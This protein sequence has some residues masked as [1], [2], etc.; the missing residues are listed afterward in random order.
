MGFL[1]RLFG[2]EEQKPAPTESRSDYR[3]QV[4]K[5]AQTN[6]RDMG[7]PN[8]FN[9]STPARPA[10]GSQAQKYVPQNPAPLKD[11]HPKVAPWEGTITSPSTPTGPPEPYKP[12][13]PDDW[14]A[15]DVQGATHSYQRNAAELKRLEGLPSEVEKSPLGRRMTWEAYD[16][17]TPDQR[18]AVDFN[19]LL[20]EAR[21]ADLAK[22]APKLTGAD[23]DAYNADVLQTFGKAGGSDVQAKETMRLLKTINFKAV[24]RDL[25]EFLS[26]EAGF[27]PM[28][29]K[30]FAFSDAEVKALENFEVTAPRAQMDTSNMGASG[31]PGTGGGAVAQGS[32]GY[33]AISNPKATVAPTQ[34][35]LAGV[36][37]DQ[38]LDTRSMENARAISTA[39]ASGVRDAY[40]GMLRSGADN[41]WTLNA[42]LGTQAEYKPEE[43]PPGYGRGPAG[44]YQLQMDQAIEQAY[45][46]LQANPNA[47]GME[48]L[49]T[50][51][52]NQAW[53]EDEKKMLWEY[54]DNRSRN[55]RDYL[56]MPEANQIRDLLG[57]K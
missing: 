12:P 52:T 2:K 28:E 13:M 19:G 57:W 49:M 29:V 55:E 38:Y 17:L 45:G 15:E 9:R 6:P 42:A 7:G 16:A 43:R 32:S 50:G 48:A 3:Q 41:S 11:S 10:V 53:T 20:F 39:L 37:F 23:L 33:P 26:M 44:S 27:S 21:E 18:A 25:D 8:L 24:G 14:F 56:G 46:L 40:A 22:D 36:D 51:L 30:N 35:V 31:Y 54:V 5:A 4:P 34:D 1:Q 47:S